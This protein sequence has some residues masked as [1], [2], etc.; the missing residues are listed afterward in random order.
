MEGFGAYLLNDSKFDISLMSGRIGEAL[1]NFF[2]LN[3]WQNIKPIEPLLLEYYFTDL[4]IALARDKEGTTAGF[5]FSAKGGSN[6]EGHN[7]ND[8]GSFMLYFNG[9][10]VMI[11]VGVG[12]YTS[13]TFSPQRYDIWTMQ[14]N[15]PVSYT[16]L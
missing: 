12:T 7:H 9:D 4:D 2:N 6:G 15:Y 16:H 10:P 3:S 5:Y 1:E 8:V 14:S 11:D 13:K